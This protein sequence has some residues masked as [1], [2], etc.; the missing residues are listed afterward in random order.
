MCV[1]ASTW[2]ALMVIKASRAP[3]IIKLTLDEL[4]TSVHTFLRQ[5]FLGSDLDA[6]RLR[7]GQ[8]IM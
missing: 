7:Q 3:K 6:R 5:F 1:L 2:L 8:V 4:L